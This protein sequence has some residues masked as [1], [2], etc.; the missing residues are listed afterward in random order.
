MASR[1]AVHLRHLAGTLPLV[2]ACFVAPA[3]AADPGWRAYERGDYAAA[4][5]LYDTAARAGDRLAQ[6]NLAMM[7]VRGEGGPADTVAGVEW[8]TKS[9]EAGMA[10]A[11]YNL[12]LLYESGVGVPRS[13]ATALNSRPVLMFTAVTSVPGSTD[14]ESSV[15]IPDTAVCCAKLTV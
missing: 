15:T 10:Q 8:L 2:L 13:L 14:L 3:Q 1:I 7:L 6:Y 9:A 11:Q 12:G 5:S 4:R